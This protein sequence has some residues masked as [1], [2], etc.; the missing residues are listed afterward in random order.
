MRVVVP[1]VDGVGRPETLAALS[2]LRSQ[3][4]VVT[5]DAGD[6]G[7]YAALLERL[8]RAGDTF[9]VVE[10]DVV[11]TK[12]Q[13]ADLARCQ[14]PWCSTCY[15]T[16]AYPR[17]PM[18]G[19]VRFDRALL[20]R[21]SEVGVHVLRTGYTRTR[22]VGWRSVNETLARHLFAI[23]ETWH[24]HQPDVVHLHRREPAGVR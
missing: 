2:W 6:D 11:P 13:L 4:E 16:A 12:A 23:G 20:E 21:R 5:L 24:R 15:D 17:T 10:H 18:L 7:A 1:W 3:L 22:H 8:W 19:L 14:H 9:M